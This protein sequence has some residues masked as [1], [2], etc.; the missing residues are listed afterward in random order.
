MSSHFIEESRK[1]TSQVMRIMML[2]RLMSQH[3][4]SDTRW[5]AGLANL[6]ATQPVRPQFRKSISGNSGSQGLRSA[7]SPYPLRT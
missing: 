7:E 6:F 1:P 3:D 5:F 2:S 4:R